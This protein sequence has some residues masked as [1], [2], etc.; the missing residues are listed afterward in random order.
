MGGPEERAHGCI[1]PA[2][3]RGFR[4][5]PCM[6]FEEMRSMLSR[7]HFLTNTAMLGSAAGFAA[8]PL[9]SAVAAAVDD[10]ETTTWSCCSINCGSRCLLRCVSKKGRV[11]RI[12]TDNTGDPEA[13]ASATSCPQ[14][15]ACQRG[16][17]IRQRLYSEERLKFPD[18]ARR[19]PRRREV[20]AHFLGTGARRDRRK[21]Q[22]DD[23][24][25]HQRIDHAHARLGQL[26][27]LQQPQLRSGSST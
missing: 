3:A 4:T 20:R 23:C 17:S 11:I 2:A 6:T 9:S 12:E 21:A 18:E 13:G 26:F 16:R 25:A 5:L 15:R 27:A 22:E 19:A 1:G 14:V 8:T 24:R 10:L 7:R